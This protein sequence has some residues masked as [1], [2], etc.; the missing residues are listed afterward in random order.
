MVAPTCHRCGAEADVVTPQG[1]H[2][3]RL[4]QPLDGTATPLYEIRTDFPDVVGALTH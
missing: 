2:L 4:H 1:E 3:C